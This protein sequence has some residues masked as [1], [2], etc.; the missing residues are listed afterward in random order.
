MYVATNIASRIKNVQ[1]AAGC[2]ETIAINPP[3]A[4]LSNK[5]SSSG[6]RNAHSHRQ[7]SL[8][9]RLKRQLPSL[10]H[11]SHPFRP[12][13]YCWCCCCANAAPSSSLAM[14]CLPYEYFLIAGTCVFR[15]AAT[16]SRCAGFATSS[17]RC[18]T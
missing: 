1:E 5:C 2:D 4:R 17:T 15:M 12:G 16:R 3:G 18:T 9:Y 13:P 6:G 14:I 8:Y 7:K 11:I 10:Q